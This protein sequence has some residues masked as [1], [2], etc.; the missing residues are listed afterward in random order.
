MDLQFKPPGP[1]AK[2]FMK[3][4]SFVRMI[5]GPVGSAKSS[6]TVMEMMRRQLMQAPDHRGFRRSRWAIIRNTN[7][8][9]RTTVMKTYEDW[10]KPEVFGEPKMAP[11]P[12][13]HEIDLDLGDGTRLVSE[14]IFLSLDSPDDVRKLLSL[15][16]TGALISEI[17]EINKQVVDGVTQRLRRFPAVKDGGC[18]WS[19]LIA[20]T[21]MPDDD[22]WLAI[23]SGLAPPPEDMSADDIASLV[24]PASWRFFIQPPAMLEHRDEKGRI[25]Y[26][27]NP[28]AE[29]IQNLDPDYYTGQIEGKTKDYIN[30]YVLNRLGATHDGRPVHPDFNDQ[31]HVATG[32]VEVFAHMPIIV[33][34]DFG[35]TPAAVFF[36]RVRE[37]VHVLDEVVLT[38]GDAEQL[39]A[40]IN[41]K[42]LERFPTNKLIVWGDPSGDNRA[43]TDRNTPFRIL[44]KHGLTAYPCETNDPE[45][46]RGALRALLT[47]MNGGRPGI[48]FDPRCKVTI[49]G[50][51]GQWHYKRVRG[52]N[53]FEDEPSKNRYSHPCEAGEYGAMGLGEGRKLMGHGSGK[54]VR[55]AN[56]NKSVTDPLGR[57]QR[58]RL[59]R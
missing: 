18:T 12:F 10:W 32:P 59:R 2:E 46:R 19:G 39:A 58:Q 57:L 9:L 56:P 35:T 44:R 22:H 29:N 4:D 23:M 33:G 47:R 53:G 36:Q 30:V 38:D 49:A 11:P 5:I 13:E 50:Y 42:K 24:K 17:R 52:T 40:A 45:I 51:K 41:R 1:M 16:L 14:N 43:Q 21:N 6:T 25:S 55:P 7:P 8:M 15:E 26:T 31:I 27:V 37:T 34:V 54:S 20:D 48:I 28:D 3:D